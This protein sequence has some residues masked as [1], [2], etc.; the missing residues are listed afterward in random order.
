[1][2]KGASSLAPLF[3]CVALTAQQAVPTA[4]QNAFSIQVVEGDAAIN[5]I[6]LHRGHDP[7]VRLVNAEGKPIE[8][9]PVTFLLPATGASGSFG[10][11][12]LSLTVPT[13]ADG[14]AAGRGLR[15]NGIA[16]EFHIRVIAAWNGSPASAT[17]TETNADPTMHAS[18]SKKI[19]IA[20][21]IAGAAV[22]GVAVAAA[23]KSGSSSP[24]SIASAAPGSIISGPPTIGPPH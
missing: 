3:Y 1:M 10:E 23:Q 2:Q 7:V 4:P 24:S 22:G 14:T 5:S 9:A 12:G 20:A 17:L 19:A 8:G 18:R 16:G 11:S 13:G 21:V 15:P 6:R